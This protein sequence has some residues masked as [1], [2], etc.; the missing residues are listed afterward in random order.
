MRAVTLY[1][2]DD[3]EALLF[4]AAVVRNQQQ[5]M[6]HSSD[7]VFRHS[8]EDPLYPE[9]WTGPASVTAMESRPC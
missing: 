9:C 3:A 4:E 5:G 2:S 8:P 7:L 6:A 1:F